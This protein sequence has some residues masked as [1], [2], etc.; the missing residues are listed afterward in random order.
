[1]PGAK[2]A[3]SG[4]GQTAAARSSQR[5]ALASAAQSHFWVLFG[6]IWLAVG[7]P[8][9]LLA[10]Y[11]IFRER[12]LASSGQIAD[13]IVLTKAVGRSGDSI[14]H[15]V[16]YRFT[17]PDGTRFE[18]KSEISEA[19]WNALTERGAVGIQYLPHRPSV[20][21]VVGATKMTLLLIFSL[22]GVLM[23]IAGGT[24]ITLS[25]RKTRTRR[26]LL[27]AGV[28]APATVA[29]V[30]PMNLRVNGRTQWRMK[31]DYQDYQNRP[32][33]QSMY[34]NAD[35]AMRWKAGDTGDVLFDPDRPQ[36]AIWLGRPDEGV[37]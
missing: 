36:S 25:L 34:L 35:E 1:M 11:F 32:H 13:G 26:R 5:G 28:R 4:A 17:A 16:T 22:V 3:N 9:V 19:S 14:H 2:E 27:T 23:S 29:E 12:Q 10:G 18:G 20:N 24:I 31:Y 33:R 15:S 21:R 7:L 30:T 6:S 8:F 37:S